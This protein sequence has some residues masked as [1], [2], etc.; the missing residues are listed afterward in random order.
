MWSYDAAPLVAGGVSASCSFFV[1]SSD[2]DVLIT[3]PPYFSRAAIALSGV[4]WPC[5]AWPGLVRRGL[6]DDH[7]QRRRARLDL[8]AHLLLERLVDPLLAQVPEQRAESSAQ[9]Q[10]R[11]RNEEQ[12]PE[13]QPPEAAPNRAAASADAAMRRRHVILALGITGD[14]GHLIGLDDQ[15]GLQLLN[16][17]DRPG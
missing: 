15:F 6:L 3:V 11:E 1:S 14:G 4:A 9:R 16:R 2:S 7:E 10:P 5:P 17:L 8:I 12:Q 13:Q